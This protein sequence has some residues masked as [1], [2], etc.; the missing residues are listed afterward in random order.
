MAAAL[1]EALEKVTAKDVN[2]AASHVKN[3]EK[4]FDKA[5]EAGEAQDAKKKEE[6]AKKEE[7][8]AKK[9]QEGQEGKGEGGEE[10]VEEE[11]KVEVEEE[12]KK[13]ASTAA[14]KVC[15]GGVGWGGVV[16]QGGMIGLG[17][18]PGA[19]GT[20]ATCRV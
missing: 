11:K 3:A 8:E 7:E 19:L 1:K 4:W 13:Q 17:V 16:F 6:A 15:G 5:R 14:A 12:E 9:A 10:K 2:G 18:V 20:R